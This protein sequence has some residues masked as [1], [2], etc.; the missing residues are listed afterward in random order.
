MS[1]PEER[2]IDRLTFENK[3]LRA[4]IQQRGYPCSPHCVGHLKELELR[5]ALHMILCNTEPD[6]IKHRSYDELAAAV[7]ETCVTAL[8]D[9]CAI[10]KP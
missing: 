10:K 4:N 9:N 2:E 1:T 7:Y 5:T 3:A 8:G 6:A